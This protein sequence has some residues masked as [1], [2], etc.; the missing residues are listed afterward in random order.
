[1]VETL[2]LCCLNCSAP[3]PLQKVFLTPDVGKCIDCEQ[4]WSMSTSYA[5]LHKQPLAQGQKT[6]PSQVAA[7]LTPPALLSPMAVISVVPAS[8]AWLLLTTLLYGSPAGEHAG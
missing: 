5:F 4:T 1:M 2:G 6:G 7:L 3:G 8:S